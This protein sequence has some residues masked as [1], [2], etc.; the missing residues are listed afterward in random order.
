MDLIFD[1]ICCPARSKDMLKGSNADIKPLDFIMRKPA[2]V[3][4]LNWI[5]NLEDSYRESLSTVVLHDV[6][7]TLKRKADVGVVELGR[8][9]ELTTYVIHRQYVNEV[10]QFK[11]N[12]EKHTSQV[13]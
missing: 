13:Q 12:K 9:C 7:K 2:L 6:I 11:K 10:L 5:E 1:V 8:G 4:V 3:H